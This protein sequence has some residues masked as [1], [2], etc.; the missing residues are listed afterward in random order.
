[1]KIGRGGGSDVIK[2]SVLISCLLPLLGMVAAAVINQLG[3]DPAKA[4]VEASG[5]W[6][7][8]LLLLC[9]AM[10][11]LRILTGMSVWLSYRRMLGLLAMFYGTLHLLAYGILLLGGDFAM[12][13]RELA[14]RPYIIVGFS[15]W[16]LMLPLAMTSTRQWQKRL[17][18][19]W[20]LLH[21]L[22]YGIALLGMVHFIWLKKIGIWAVWPYAVILTIL[23]LL[24][25]PGIRRFIIQIRSKMQARKMSSD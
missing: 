22:V 5:L 1:M 21:K 7:F 17:G 11:P 2:L 23:L 4:L 3:P 15:A 19:Q 10:T 13:S 12:L 20:L 9:L 6:A 16:L 25:V 14:K 24:R 8:R 18:K